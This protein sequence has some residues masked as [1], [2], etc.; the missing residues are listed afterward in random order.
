M[1]AA[2]DDASPDW[3]RAFDWEDDTPISMAA[4]P[5]E[6]IDPP[7]KDLDKTKRKLDER[8]HAAGVGFRVFF[9]F[10][11]GRVPLLAAGTTYYLFLGLISLLIFAYGLIAV[12]GADQLSDWLTES[13][14]NAFPGLIGD[15]GIS[16]ADLR[17]FG[18]TTSAVG[19]L[20]S[21]YS[22]SATI[23]A[24]SQ[25]IHI[26]YG[27]PKDPRNIVWKKVRL[28]G[29]LL[30]IAP[31]IMLSFAPA[32]LVRTFL[33]PL[34]ERTGIEETSVLVT[35]IWM[36]TLAVS[37]LLNVLS[38][39]LLLSHVGGIRPSRHARMVGALI[40]GIA[41]E[42]IKELSAS[43]VEWSLDKPQY[44]TFAV[45]ITIMLVLYLLS[46]TLYGSACITAAS[47]S[48][49]GEDGTVRG[50]RSG[51]GAELAE[52]ESPAGESATVQPVAQES[53]GPTT[54]DS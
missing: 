31:L 43:I 36:V 5:G 2:Q 39:Y 40:G 7:P 22:G 13:V 17:S 30:L 19:L 4:I 35:L 41:V 8:H 34:L 38:I 53:P 1:T 26:I 25:A 10:T 11:H 18:S 24:A 47:A 37:L 21:L 28:I 52:G 29:W 33:D 45:P 54:K 42:V 3:G 9:R 12:L 20:F 6:A 15:Q 50:H 23:G 14:Q 49:D 27:A 16:P 46:L 51:D 44:G 32:V 48:K